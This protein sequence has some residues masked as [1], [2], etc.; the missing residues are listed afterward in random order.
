MLQVLDI[1]DEENSGRQNVL[2]YKAFPCY[3]II[4]LLGLTVGLA[5]S[6]VVGECL[7]TDMVFLKVISPEKALFEPLYPVL[8]VLVAFFLIAR[9]VESPRLVL[10]ALLPWLLYTPLL[11]FDLNIFSIITFVALS[12]ISICRLAIVLPGLSLAAKT[13]T[14]G[15]DR[16]WLLLTATVTA[17]FTAIGIYMSHVALK[18][19]F[20]CF[21]DW[22]IFTEVAANTL[23]G[24][25]LLT[26]WHGGINFFSHH[27]TPGFFLLFTPLI[28]L[29]N[30][31]YTTIVFG[32]LTLWGSAMLIYWFARTRQLDPPY[33]F[34]LALAYLLYPSLSNLNISIFYGFHIIYLFI[35]VFILFYVF[36]EREKYF[37]AFLIFLY[38]L[39][40]QE[41]VGT[42]WVGWGIIQF[43]AG[44]K[45]DGVIYAVIGAAFFIICVKLLI[46]ACG[47]DNYIYFQERYSHLGTGIW[48][49]M[50][51]PVLHPAAFWGSLFTAKNLA[52]LLLL[53][54]SFMVAFNRPLLLLCSA[55]QLLFVFIQNN[56]EVINLCLQYQSETV[57]MI[58]VTAVIG[59]AA[60]LKNEKTT[61]WTRILFAG[62]LKRET[63]PEKSN[64]ACAM[65]AGLIITS[66]LANYFCSL[67]YYGC[68]SFRP[69]GNMPD[70]TSVMNE[71]KK[72]VPPDA[73]VAASERLG[74]QLMIRNQVFPLSFEKEYRAYDLSDSLNDSARFHNA[75]LNSREYGLIW[76]KLYQGHQFFVFKKGAAK[77]ATP[78]A[79]AK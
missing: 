18:V 61:C 11:F 78:A 22:G 37:I 63:F 50:T 64:I 23:A 29:F 72:I 77:P 19:Q 17:G 52:I 75:M 60:V 21:G 54:P 49:I 1:M 24:K 65:V 5:I 43:L 39:T 7:S 26:N 38:S 51:S 27:F 67:S 25:F 8:F 33:A 73:A 45:R 42:F 16:T 66:V 55:P 6:Q 10:L 46:P 36:Y 9:Y 12:G 20:L 30:S 71:M 48:G 40:I 47:T 59:L 76:F 62:L 69:I 53:L 32:A 56:Q 79:I 31:P 2:L 70:C 68:Y 35:P 57:A 34:C 14:A 13:L 3:F 44:R 74:A 4:G 41:T 15:K 58:N 28:W